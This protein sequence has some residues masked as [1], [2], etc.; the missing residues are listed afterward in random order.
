[1]WEKF[2][3]RLE[4][5]V[6]I[7]SNFLMAADSTL[8]FIAGPFFQLRSRAAM[9]DGTQARIRKYLSKNRMNRMK[10]FRKYSLGILTLVTALMVPSWAG[11]G[12]TPEEFEQNIN[13]RETSFYREFFDR[14]LYEPVAG[15]L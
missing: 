11:F 13:A 4:I 6:L 3:R 9:R 12:I 2:L 15:L 10:R 14:I 8:S 1:M 7:S 5:L